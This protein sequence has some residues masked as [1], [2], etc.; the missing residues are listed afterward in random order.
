MN[1]TVTMELEVYA[2]HP[3][4]TDW[5]W[6]I[7]GEPLFESESNDHPVGFNYASDSIVYETTERQ[8][9]Y[10]I[11]NPTVQFWNVSK[12][13]CGPTYK[14]TGKKQIAAALAI[15]WEEI[16]AAFNNQMERRC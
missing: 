14:V 15:F 7:T 10:D 4:T 13:G 2:T 16:E 5:E 3:K 8:E 11:K 12:S 1:Q 9:L 6:L